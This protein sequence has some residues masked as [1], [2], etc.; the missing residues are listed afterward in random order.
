MMMTRAPKFLFC[1]SLINKRLLYT[2]YTFVCGL[3]SEKKHGFL[4]EFESMLGSYN[5]YSI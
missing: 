2:L 3:F 1:S 4:R 5:I